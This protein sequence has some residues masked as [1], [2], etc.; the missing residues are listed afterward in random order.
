MNSKIRSVDVERGRICCDKLVV[1]EYELWR[2]RYTERLA[3]SS[4]PD[5]NTLK[6]REVIIALELVALVPL[7]FCEVLQ[8]HLEDPCEAHRD[9]P[10]RYLRLSPRKSKTSSSLAQDIAAAS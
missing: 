2:L 8:E 1:R 10:L 4:E 3:R 7:G 9:C 6:G 5:T